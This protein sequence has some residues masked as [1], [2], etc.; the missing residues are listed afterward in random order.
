MKQST[1]YSCFANLGTSML[2]KWKSACKS[3]ELGVILWGHFQ[4]LLELTVSCCKKKYLFIYLYWSFHPPSH[5]HLSFGYNWLEAAENKGAHP[6]SQIATSK[7]DGLLYFIG[8]VF[9]MHLFLAKEGLDIVTDMVY[10]NWTTILRKLE[11]MQ[12]IL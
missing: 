3:S 10:C 11:W 1:V 8:Q 6:V 7:T 2:P 4:F 9:L 5:P 12:V